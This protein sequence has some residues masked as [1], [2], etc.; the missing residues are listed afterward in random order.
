MES[1][2]GKERSMF[3]CFRDKDSSDGYS[4]LHSDF[5]IELCIGFWFEFGNS[6]RFSVCGRFSSR[7]GRVG[8]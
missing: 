1:V 6:S 4:E 3:S 5:E 7:I 2:L 8:G